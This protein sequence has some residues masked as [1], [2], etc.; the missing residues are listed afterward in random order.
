[1]KMTIGAAVR[2]IVL[3]LA[4]I[5]QWLATKN[6]SPIA[7]DEDSISSILLTIAA[8][9]GWY[10]NNP[11]SKEGHEAHVEMKQ[12][13]V[14]KKLPTTGKAPDDFTSNNEGQI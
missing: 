10:K 2:F 8:L 14:E 4:L 9:Y 5:N 3:I 6:I 13:K 12:K 1:M 11:T 7:V